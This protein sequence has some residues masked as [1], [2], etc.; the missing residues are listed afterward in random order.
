[1]K[2]RSLQRARLASTS[3]AEAHI[4]ELQ[5]HQHKAQDKLWQASG[6][7]AKP[8]G[9]SEIRSESPDEHASCTC[10]RTSSSTSA[11][12]WGLSCIGTPFNTNDEG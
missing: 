11:W 6:Q 4:E 1:M 8:P 7:A 2:G 12:K 3:K 10:V 9:C 5:A